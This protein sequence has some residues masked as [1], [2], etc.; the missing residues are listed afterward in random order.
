MAMLGVKLTAQVRD[1]NPQPP[2]PSL[3]SQLADPR[4]LEPSQLALTAV[5]PICPKCG[6]PMTWPSRFHRSFVKSDPL[7]L[8]PIR[9]RA[10]CGWSG[11][12]PRAT[13][14]I[15]PVRATLTL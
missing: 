10:S 2:V 15:F 4:L 1:I 11:V 12:A 8:E 5:I 3:P 9:C 13:L 14:I 6:E 7:A